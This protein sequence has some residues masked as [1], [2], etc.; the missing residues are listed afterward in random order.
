M[1][2]FKVQGMTCGH[3]VRAITSAITEADPQARVEVELA[4]GRVAVDSTLAAQALIELIEGEG[5][6]AHRA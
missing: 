6:A 2:E 4:G 5:Y 3:C 1:Q